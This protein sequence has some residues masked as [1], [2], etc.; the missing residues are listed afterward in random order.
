MVHLAYFVY[1]VYLVCWLSGSET[2]LE[3][4]IDQTDRRDQADQMNQSDERKRYFSG[5][6]L[7][8]SISLMGSR[9]LALEMSYF[10][11]SSGRALQGVPYFMPPC[12]R[13]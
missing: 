1:F 9:F 2:P 3:N 4:Q 11:L 5:S 12:V 13:L 8:C 6:G 10:S 7:P